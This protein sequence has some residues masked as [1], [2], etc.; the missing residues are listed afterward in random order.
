VVLRSSVQQHGGTTH[1]R[2][3]PVDD[4]AC[5]IVDC[6]GGTVDKR[7]AQAEFE[8]RA[9]V[10]RVPDLA[11]GPLCQPFL[12]RIDERDH[13]FACVINHLVFD[14]WSR[15]IFLHE[16]E[17]LYEAH[18]AGRQPALPPPARYAD[19]VAWQR[20]RFTGRAFEEN[21][22]AMAARLA[23]SAA[24]G[25]SE[26]AA[27]G[28]CGPASASTLRISASRVE[29][30]QRTCGERRVMLSVALLA[31]F[32]NTLHRF[33]GLRDLLVGIPLADR[34]GPPFRDVVGLFIDVMVLRTHDRGEE[35]VEE[36]LR[37]VR[38]GLLEG[39]AVQRALPYAAFV[40]WKHE[41]HIEAADYPFLFSFHNDLRDVELKLPGV[42]IDDVGT[43]VGHKQCLAQMG[44]QIAWE[45]GELWCVLSSRLADAA[46]MLARFFAH[47]DRAVT[48][49]ANGD[50]A[51]ADPAPPSN[52][53]DTRWIRE[54]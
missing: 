11:R 25:R 14:D 31:A 8:L 40:H 45:R 50:G 42:E 12:W 3:Q 29:A 21:A 24:A 27:V 30:L 20:S 26:L 9:E 17:I 13:L 34:R 5:R 39:Y 19:Y 49:L 41:H 10:A 28:S 48:A 53:G 22:A 43:I 46:P 33:T 44:I 38:D 2:I 18:A 23:P 35:P 15:K 1:R 7:A 51:A 32:V 36:T 54:T 16:L 6:A 52:E 37:A 47:F 4:S